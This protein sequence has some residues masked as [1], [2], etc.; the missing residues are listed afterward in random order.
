MSSKATSG[1]GKGGAVR[2]RKVLRD[3]IT[4]ITK[5][6]LRRLARR[7]GVKR[8]SGLCYEELRSVLKVFLARELQT[9]VAVTEFARLKTIGAKQVV[10][11]SKLNGI[12]LFMAVNERSRVRRGKTSAARGGSKSSS[13]KAKKSK[14]PKSGTDGKSA[15]SGAAD[16]KSKSKAKSSSKG[17]GRPLQ[18][19]AKS[20]SKA[21]SKSAKAPRKQVASKAARKSAASVGGVKKPHRFRPGTGKSVV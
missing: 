17:T 5:P 13:G 1:L 16:G 19:A 12:R 3:N 21:G 18:G 4:G 11:G 2:H 10:I 8:I 15:K 6:A 20:S 9:I 14:T 7:A